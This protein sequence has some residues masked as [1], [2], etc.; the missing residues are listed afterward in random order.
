MS[1]LSDVL[2]S[3]RPQLAAAAC[4]LGI[5]LGACGGGG[6][7]GGSSSAPPPVPAMQFMP[8]SVTVNMNSVLTWSATSGT[9]CMAS[10]S[11]TGSKPASGMLTVMPPAAGSYKYTLTC[12][13]GGY[14]GSSTQSATLMVTAAA[15]FAAIN[16][17]HDTARAGAATVDANLVNP[18]GMALGTTTYAWVAN[19]HTATSTLYDG[20]GAAQP[21]G[22][23]LVVNFAAGFLPT[24]AV[25]NGS[26]DFMVSSA[27]RSGAALFLYA[28]EG[29][30][31]AGWSQIVDAT[32]AITMY[33]DAHGA[34]YTGLA[35]ANNGAGNFLYAADFHNGK[36]DVFNST[37]VKQ[38]A[39]ASSFT[40]VDPTLPAGYAPFG[41]QALKTG[42]AGAA[43]I[44]VSYAKQSPPGNSGMT[45]AGLGLVDVFD[46]NG[47]FLS[48]LVPPGGLLNAPWGLALAPADFGT[49]S[50]AV[51]VGNFGDGKINGYD[52]LTGAVIATV[53]DGTGTAF[54]APG[55]W[56]IAFGNDWTAALAHNKLFYTA[57]TSGEAHGVFGSISS[58]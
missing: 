29:G 34:V 20:T 19:N 8:S 25:Y 50:N 53:A 35:I 21:A 54:A 40:F 2:K 57:G 6:Y 10:D 47:K 28:S 43:Q 11:W 51:L 33:T 27:G 24:G 41:I 7:G 32:H 16:L 17:A 38:T 4:I 37:F 45:G 48:Q 5:A 42:A 31:I 9:S 3:A 26:R 56:S 44:Y 49:L 15:G 39:T 55:L 46:T 18:R 52:A 22:A 14:G 30:S 23:P 13:G 12:S 1:Q 58:L 36:V